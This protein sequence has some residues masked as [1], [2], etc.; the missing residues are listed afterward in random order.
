MISCLGSA[1]ELADDDW[2][3][4]RNLPRHLRSIVHVAIPANVLI[5]RHYI[6][7]LVHV[8]LQTIVVVRRSSH[9][10]GHRNEACGVLRAG[11][12]GQTAQELVALGRVRRLVG[13]RPN[14]DVSAVVVA[15]NHIAQLCLSV[16]VG[17]EVLPGDGP[18]DRNLR[19]HQDAHAFGLANGVFVV[20]IVCQTYEIAA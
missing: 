2:L 16:L 20:R 10:H 5:E 17:A 13:N 4:V 7:I 19:P 9:L 14:D 8:V 12:S 6:D 3:V 1:A 15:S 11:I 18:I